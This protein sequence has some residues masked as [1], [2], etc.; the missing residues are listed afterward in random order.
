MYILFK[1]KLYLE[2]RN[3]QVRLKASGFLPDHEMAVILRF[4]SHGR[5]VGTPLAVV[6]KI[7]QNKIYMT[8]F[9]KN[10]FPKIIKNFFN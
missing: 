1:K 6:V 8:L 10:N 3:T 9:F 4:F 2:T 7:R 5:V